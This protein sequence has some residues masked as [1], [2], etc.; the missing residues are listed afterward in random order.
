MTTLIH[1]INKLTLLN[2]LIISSG[3]DIANPSEALYA[4]EDEIEQLEVVFLEVKEQ[5]EQ[6]V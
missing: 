1:K 6:Y 3:L 5:L 2:R 4:I